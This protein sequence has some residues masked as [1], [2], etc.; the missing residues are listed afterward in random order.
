MAEV[1]SAL[2]V[3]VSIC[4]GHRETGHHHERA[5]GELTQLN[6][7]VLVA[8]LTGISRDLGLH[9]RGVLL[10]LYTCIV[11]VGSNCSNVQAAL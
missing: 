4:A 8:Q 2:F 6:S 5:R 7:E 10:L 11:A 1:P 3:R 9:S